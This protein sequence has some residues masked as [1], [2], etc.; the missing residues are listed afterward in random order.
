[1]LDIGEDDTR[2]QLRFYDMSA[3]ERHRQPA[4]ASALQSGMQLY[5]ERV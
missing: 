3:L 5:G 4:Q 1:M 2:H